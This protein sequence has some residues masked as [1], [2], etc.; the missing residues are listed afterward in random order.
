VSGGFSF[1]DGFGTGTVT[2][3]GDTITV[4]YRPGSAPAVALPAGWPASLVPKAG[5]TG[6]V[7]RATLASRDANGNP[8]VTFVPSVALSAAQLAGVATA[9]TA[10]LSPQVALDGGVA[11]ELPDGRQG[12]WV[13]TRGGFVVTLAAATP[14]PS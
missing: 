4:E 12:S 2:S 3:S 13:T 14:S 6:A 1:D 8:S 5:T 10:G 7:F 9:S 11:F